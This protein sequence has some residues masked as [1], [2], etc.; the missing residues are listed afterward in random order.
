M[1]A[2]EEAEAPTASTASSPQKKGNRPP[3]PAYRIDM[4]WSDIKYSEDG[5]ASTDASFDRPIEIYSSDAGDLRPMEIAFDAA[6]VSLLTKNYINFSVILLI[7]D[8]RIR[9]TKIYRLL[10]QIAL[11][12]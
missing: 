1:A 10:W 4:M 5:E 3:T 8:C 9:L 12:Q 7:F 2:E 11:G 6:A